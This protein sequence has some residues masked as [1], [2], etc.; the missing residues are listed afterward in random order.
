MQINNRLEEIQSVNA[1]LK[2]NRTQFDSKLESIEGS[3]KAN[4]ERFKNKFEAIEGSLHAITQQLTRMSE[5][6]EDSGKSTP[7]LGQSVLDGVNAIHMYQF[8]PSGAD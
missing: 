8:S 1:S 5:N 7:E 4:Y 3:L 6:T 2:T